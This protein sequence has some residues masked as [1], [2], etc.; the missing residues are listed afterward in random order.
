M[1]DSSVYYLVRLGTSQQS[2]YGRGEADFIIPIRSTDPLDRSTTF[3]FTALSK[4]ITITIAILNFLGSFEG[5]WYLLLKSGRHDQTQE[6]VPLLLSLLLHDCSSTL[7]LN[8][9]LSPRLQFYS[10]AVFPGACT[11]IA[12]GDLRW[13]NRG[14]ES[15]AAHTSIIRLQHYSMDP[16]TWP[17]TTLVLIDS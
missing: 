8:N 11:R 2:Y 5:T 3:R 12:Q 9:R 4:T 14:G 15:L 10:V 13:V 16:L 6:L 1:L 7:R 17:D